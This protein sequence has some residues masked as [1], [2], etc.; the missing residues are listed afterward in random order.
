MNSPLSP[1]KHVPM[2]YQPR[3]L[4]I[5][6]SKFYLTH[7]RLP[8][9]Y[10]AFVATV[11]ILRCSPSLCNFYSQLAPSTIK[12]VSHTQSILRLENIFNT[13]PQLAIS[14]RSNMS[15]CH[16]KQMQILSFYINNNNNNYFNK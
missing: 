12:K 10:R 5:A 6:M 15:Q 7:H 13:I 14:S 11:C 9:S 4:R 1:W 8:P 3:F 2:L 16:T